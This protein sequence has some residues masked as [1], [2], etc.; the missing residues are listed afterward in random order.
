MKKL[1]RF[2]ITM[3]AAVALILPFSRTQIKAE[4][5]SAEGGD[6]SCVVINT[7]KDG[8]TYFSTDG[9]AA[10]GYDFG[11]YDSSKLR[12]VSSDPS[13]LSV[14]N[15]SAVMNERELDV[16]YTVKGKSLG[17]AEVLM[18][19]GDDNI[20]K[21]WHYIYD[22]TPTDNASVPMF[23]LYNPN[24][25][26]HF[27]TFDTKEKSTLV[28]LG[29]TD[30][31]TGWNAPSLGDP[32]YR[33]YNANGG[34]HHYTLSTKERDA[35]VKAGWTY[36]GVGWY[37]DQN[38]GVPVY[39]Q[40]NPNAFANNHN[41]TTSEHEKDALISLGWRDENTAWYGVK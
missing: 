19:Y 12:V 37:S 20:S 7:T 15:F 9:S 29:W 2:F 18:Y 35:L 4:V 32:V 1:F 6:E 33:L 30:E 26:E 10:D 14:E 23:R 22:V 39:R 24:S 28:S 27:Y 25:G 40:Y 11:T 38:K 31:G 8:A 16:R 17:Q 3:A 36:E 13:V 5:K 34:E 21:G 41:Y